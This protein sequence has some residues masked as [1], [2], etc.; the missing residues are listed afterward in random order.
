MTINNEQRI[1]IVAT[2]VAAMLKRGEIFEDQMLQL[3]D[4]LFAASEEQLQETCE[5]FC[6]GDW[7]A[8]KI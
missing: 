2:I 7:P 1:D 3:R 8:A 5:E 4:E 6:P